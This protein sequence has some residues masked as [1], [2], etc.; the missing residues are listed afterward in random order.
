MPGQAL[1]L[2]T[3]GDDCTDTYVVEANDTCEKVVAAHGPKLDLGILY[4]NNPQLNTKCDN[5]YIG[6]VCLLEL[7]TRWEIL[8]IIGTMRGQYGCCASTSLWCNSSF[9]DTHYGI[10][11]NHRFAMVR[12][13]YA[14]V[15]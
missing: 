6:E 13:D 15:P 2:G 4:H 5:M 3:P 14:S 8:H 7:S 1:C 12:L 10:S 9:L 11:S